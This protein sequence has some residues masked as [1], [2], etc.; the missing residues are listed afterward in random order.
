MRNID[1]I[2]RALWKAYNNADPDLDFLAGHLA[3]QEIPRLRGEVN[4]ILKELDGE[5]FAI[6]SRQLQP[7]VLEQVLREALPKR[8]LD[9][10]A[11]LGGAFRAIYEGALRDYCRPL[12]D[13]LIRQL[14]ATG[15]TR[16]AEA[17][18]GQPGP[19]DPL[20]RRAVERAADLVV[21]D[22]TG[23]GYVALPGK[24]VPSQ[25]DALLKDSRTA[26]ITLVFG[27]DRANIASL[28][29]RLVQRQRIMPAAATAA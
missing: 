18:R 5:G 28:Y 7:D 24:A 16:A 20:E 13:P 12:A 9:S 3:T 8:S 1:I 23:A 6:A 22:L 26:S 25:I 19:L 17:K 10:A 27:E 2:A 4:Y 15:L 14:I 11:S 29:G 21:E